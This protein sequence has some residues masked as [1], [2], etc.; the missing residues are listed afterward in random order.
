M[1]TFQACEQGHVGVAAIL[2]AKDPK[3][4]DIMDK[5]DK[6]PSDYIQQNNSGFKKLFATT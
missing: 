1:A 4:K 3:V 2:L 6:V 5:R